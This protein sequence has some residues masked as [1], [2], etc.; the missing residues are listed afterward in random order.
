MPQEFICNARFAF[1]SYLLQ[2][3][4]DSAIDVLKFGVRLERASSLLL[5]LRLRFAYS[6]S[7][8]FLTISYADI[9][10]KIFTNNFIDVANEKKCNAF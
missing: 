3:L 6:D 7:G 5:H 8:H 1:T 10:D 4:C 2:Y 9:R